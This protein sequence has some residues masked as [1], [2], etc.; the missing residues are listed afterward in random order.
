MTIGLLLIIIA[1][2]L[3]VVACFPPM[4]NYFLLNIALLLVCIAL[5]LQSGFV[6]A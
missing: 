5:I 1:L 3:S 2:V 6:H 4:R